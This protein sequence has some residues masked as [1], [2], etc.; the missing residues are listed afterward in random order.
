[1]PIYEYRCNQ[2]QR[3]TSL[4]V[5]SFSTPA[6]AAC[7]F[8]GSGE[9]TRIMSRFAYHRAESDRLEGLDTSR[10]PGDDYYRDSRNV[11]LWAKKRAQQLGVD[12][13]LKP[14][15]DEIV[16]NAHAKVKDML[17]D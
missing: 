3:K 5:R 12:D 11:G 15:F 14:H 16:D 7:E 4:L 6:T 10:P 1:M 17:G 13:V 2:C 8:C 9:V